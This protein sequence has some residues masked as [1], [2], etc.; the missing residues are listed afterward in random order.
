MASDLD[1][2]DPVLPRRRKVPRRFEGDAPPEYPPT[3]KDMY[4]RVYYEALDLL[5]QTI[6][7]TKET[8]QRSLNKCSECTSLI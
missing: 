5:V 4:R 7:S 1:V 6:Q 2:N 3:P 8:T